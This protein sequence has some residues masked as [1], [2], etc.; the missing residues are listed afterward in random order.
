M[1]RRCNDCG[2]LGSTTTCIKV[3]KPICRSCCDV[4]CGY[5]FTCWGRYY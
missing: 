3:S 2:S 5:N 1:F 4:D